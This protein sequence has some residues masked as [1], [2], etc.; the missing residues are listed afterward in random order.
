MRWAGARGTE[1]YS[2]MYDNE[3]FNIPVGS[4]L[5]VFIYCWLVCLLACLIFMYV[6]IMILCYCNLA[7]TSTTMMDD[8]QI[9]KI[10]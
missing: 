1:H 5:L 2:I 8:R 4:C 3:G 6:F 7:S 9:G 10:C